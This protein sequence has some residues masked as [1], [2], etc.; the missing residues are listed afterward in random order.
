M[1]V[2][3][4]RTRL[5]FGAR[6]RVRTWPG[7]THFRPACSSSTDSDVLQDA[8]YIFGGDHGVIRQR[9]E[10][11]VGPPSVVPH[12]QGARSLPLHVASVPGFDRGW[13]SLHAR[14]AA[15]TS[16]RRGY[17]GLQARSR[18]SWSGGAGRATL[19][20]R[21]CST[22]ASPTEDPTG[23]SSN[24]ADRRR[25]AKK[26]ARKPLLQPPNRPKVLHG[27]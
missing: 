16:K 10:H 9:Q 25:L 18:H 13:R 26:S 2:H 15:D 27:P 8:M 23:V 21:R 4:R 11:S 12:A 6:P 22:G 19:L 17:R 3:L 7:H 14:A 5:T 20:T 1:H 24:R